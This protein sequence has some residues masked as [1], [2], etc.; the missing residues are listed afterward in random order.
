MAAKK[1]KSRKSKDFRELENAHRRSARKKAKPKTK[2]LAKKTPAPQDT[3]P[4]VPAVLPLVEPV[5]EEEPKAKDEEEPK[6]K[7]EFFD[8]EEMKEFSVKD[9]E[10]DADEESGGGQG[11]PAW[12]EEEY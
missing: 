7:D 4:A 5:E 3:K 9:E 10:E 1:A 8:E 11:E 2:Y 6:A 12:D